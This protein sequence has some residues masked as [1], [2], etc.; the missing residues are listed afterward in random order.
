MDAVKNG[1]YSDKV[2][3]GL[4]LALAVIDT[5]VVFVGIAAAG[6]AQG[7]AL[8]AAGACCGPI[9]LGERHD[10][11]KNIRV[12][13]RLTALPVLASCGRHWRGHLDHFLVCT[14]EAASSR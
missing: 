13:R 14:L 4:N 9:G 1:S 8:A 5:C 2:Y 10:K 7:T 6:A 11:K 12:P 3:A